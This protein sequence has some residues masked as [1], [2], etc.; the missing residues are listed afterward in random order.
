MV[1]FKETSP[2]LQEREKPFIIPEAV[3]WYYGRKGKALILCTL[4]L[5]L[6]PLEAELQPFLSELLLL[7]P[8]PSLFLTSFDLKEQIS[9]K[10]SSLLTTGPYFK[11]MWLELCWWARGERVSTAWHWGI[12]DPYLPQGPATH[13]AQVASP[14]LQGLSW[15]KREEILHCSHPKSLALSAW[16]KCFYGPGPWPHQW[17]VMGWSSR[18]PLNPERSEKVWRECMSGLSWQMPTR[19]IAW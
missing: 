10:A 2:K 1:I 5:Y 4:P 6:A 15:Q 11:E 13:S 9:H 8:A 16:A 12:I 14:I 19:R 3:I 18:G 7:Y 17:L